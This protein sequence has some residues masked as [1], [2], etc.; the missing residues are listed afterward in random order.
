VRFGRSRSSKVSYFGTNRKSVCDFLVVRHSNLGLIL[1]RF[2]DIAGFWAHDPPL[3]HPNFG[4]V[5]VIAGVGVSPSIY[6]NWAYQPWIYFQSI[7]TYVITP[8]PSLTRTIAFTCVGWQVTLC[9]PIWQVMS[10]SSEMGFPRRAMWPFS[11]FFHGTWAS[12]T[13]RQTDRRYTVA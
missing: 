12:R 7:P 3:F 4:D 1:H 9:D 11:T 10:R 13:D 8:N 6:L 2:G 5:P